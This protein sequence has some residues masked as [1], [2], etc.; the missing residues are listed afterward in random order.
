[1]KKALLFAGFA[2]LALCASAQNPFAYGIRT[3]GISDGIATGKT[4]TVNYTLNADA[5]SGAI[6]FYNTG[7]NAVK[8]VD[9]AGDQLTKGTHAVEVSIDDLQ[10]N[11]AYGFTITTTGAKIDAV[12]E[13]FSDF[14]A[15]MAHQYWSPY[16]VAC[17]NNPM[18]KHFGRVLITESQAN[19]KDTYFTKAHGVGP[20]LYEY[21]P[22]GNPVVN[23]ANSTTYGY[24][25]FQWVHATYEGGA[26]STKFFAKK[27]RIA[28]DGRIFLG[29][30]DCVSNPLYTI[31]PDNLG[32]W[33]PVFQGTLATDASGLINNAEGAMVAAPSAAF[34]VVGKGENLKI[35]NLGSKFG[36]SYN[37]G[38]YTCYEYA[39]GTTN[40][41]S[42]AA[43]AK[44][45]PYSEQYTISSQSVS[46]AYDKDGNGM[47]YAQYRA[48]PTDEQPAIKHISLKD[49]N[50][51][52][53]YSDITTVV[54]GGGIAYN[55]DYTLLAIPAGN[56]VLKVYTVDKDNDG[57]PVLTEKYVLNTPSIR[58]YNDICFDYANNIYS[59]DNGKEVMQQ[60]QLPLE[61][62]TVEVPCPES[63]LFSIPVSTGVTDITSTE[64]KA[65]KVIENGQVVI[66]KGDKK[67]NLMGVEIK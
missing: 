42:E 28:K 60:L 56:N 62:P 3:T 16:G 61:N 38:N 57:K 18:S 29:V 23:G 63:E 50:W 22:Q 53:D 19:Q 41:W 2:A 66:I 6:K 7:K 1:M 45:E 11:A 21:D 58:G 31:N 40:T 26:K 54:R 48:T 52:E 49:G 47:W 25:P 14:G 5:E 51:V 37:Y 59:C 30:L 39:L 64:V 67:Y 33:T 34:D 4:I 8:A 10:A 44:V 24:N 43:T 15:G 13:V 17:D 27:V 46:I 65:K 20:G 32:E 12:K 55:K 9:L 35:A 36:Q